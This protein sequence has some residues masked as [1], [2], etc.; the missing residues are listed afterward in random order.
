MQGRVGYTRKRNDRFVIYMN[1]QMFIAFPD[2]GQSFKCTRCKRPTE[3]QLYFLISCTHN[4]FY[5]Y[6]HQ[7]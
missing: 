6:H 4:V 1:T 3:Q 2:S 7:Q 5:I